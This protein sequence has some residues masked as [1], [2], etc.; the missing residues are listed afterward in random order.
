MAC[1]YR[2]TGLAHFGHAVDIQGALD[3]LSQLVLGFVQL[4]GPCHLALRFDLVAR[5]ILSK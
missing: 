3:H 4:I 1:D 2:T 5:F